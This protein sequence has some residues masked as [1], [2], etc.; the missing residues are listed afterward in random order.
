MNR[1]LDKVNAEYENVHHSYEEHFWSTKMKLEGA[2]ADKLSSSKNEYDSFLSSA[3]R[4]SAVREQLN[5][6]GLSAEQRHVLSCMEKTF[7]WGDGE[8]GRCR[9]AVLAGGGLSA[10]GSQTCWAS[11]TGSV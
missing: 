10:F 9:A 2:S 6:E 7:R 11:T 8:G 5:A 3:A 1:F 4:L